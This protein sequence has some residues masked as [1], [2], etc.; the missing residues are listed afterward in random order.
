MITVSDVKQ[1]LYCP[2]IIYF[3]HVLH[4]PKPSDQKLMTGKELH[5]TITAREK[6]RKGALFYD[7]ELDRAQK[8]FR[9]A[10]ESSSLGL[11]GILDYLFKTDREYIPVDYKFGSSHNGAAFLNHK[12]QLAAYSLLVEDCFKTIVR[13][14]FVHYSKERINVRVDLS[15]ELRLRTMKV[16]RQTAEIIDEEREP[17]GTKDLGRCIDCEYKRYCIA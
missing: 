4:V 7:P 2:R 13:R 5:D 12:Y 6:R 3:D 8:M 15:D 1:Y 10:L 11:R 17:A 9:V 16:I 14:S